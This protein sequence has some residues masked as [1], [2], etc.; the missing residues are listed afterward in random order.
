MSNLEFDLAEAFA[1]HTRKHCFVTGR[2]GTGKTTLLKRIAERSQ[3]NVVV[4]APTGVAAV[5][6][7]GATL[8]S[9]FGL[10]LTCFVPNDDSVDPR[11]ATN[12]R[13][14]L[15]EHLRLRKEKV[16]VLRELDLLIIDEVS[17][18]RCDMLDA[19]DLV[20]RR[21]RDERRPFGG[22]QVLLIGDVHQLP[23]VARDAEWSV[24][25]RYYG[26]PYFFDSLVW[27][28]LDAARIELQ[29]IYRQNDARF[30][31][32][33]ENI[34]NCK[35]DPADEQNL[36]ERY[37][38]QFK[39]AEAGHVL[40]TTHNRKADDVNAAELNALA[41]NAYSFTAQID[42]EFP[43]HLYPC[44]H[45]LRLKP[46]AQVM[47]IRNDSQEGRYY[48]GKLA[49]VKQIDGENV[50][51]TF[52]DSG[53]DYILRRE[54]WENIGYSVE[55]E[56]GKVVKEELGT[57]SQ[58]PLRL[59][60][61]ITIH[62]SQGLTFDKVTVDAARS[63]E[64]GQVYV[65]LSRCRTLE[66][67]VL[68]SRITADALRSNGRIGDFSAS[69]HHANELQELLGPEKAR[70]ANE[71]LMR[72]FTFGEW[73]EAMMEWQ[74]LIAAQKHL[75]QESAVALHARIAA[76]SS[77]IK[78]T[79][80]KFQQQLRRLIHVAERDTSDAVL[81]ER[82]AKAIEYFTA[83]I[84]TQLVPPLREHIAVLAYKQKL[85]R[86]VRHVQFIEERCWTKIE[87]LY[88]AQ[89]LDR[90]LYQ[91]EIAHRRNG[92]STPAGAAPRLKKEKGAT[93]RD[94]LDLYRQG[95]TIEQIAALR[96]L[97]IGT[98]KSHME[99]WIKSG[100]IDLAEIL[101]APLIDAVVAFIEENPSATL[102]QIR[103]AT[104]GA[105]D[106]SDIRLV[107]A[108]RDREEAE[109]GEGDALR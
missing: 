95:N 30:L 49:T 87:R 101:P 53:D 31:S 99:R 79:A 24:L 59:A 47:F 8:H 80:E 11:V 27:P 3:K 56:S 1:L 70:Y 44:E 54:V 55:R 102:T 67:I 4:V 93:Y 7:G 91:G 72:L 57:F 90:K 48:N 43:E 50:T 14:F 64:A 45:T 105:Y 46:G 15:S 85:K 73:S 82:C 23:P 88:A 92:S 98:I 63:F 96:G 52:R 89:F 104:G 34:R 6:A 94:T 83:Q 13:Q 62:K 51:V 66:G 69:H 108:H 37:D 74:E 17:M 19:V 25:Q 35:L 60:W 107:K 29:T 75:D 21:V 12:R 77:E 65:A 81:K 76:S 32:L 68:Q 40:L 2:A 39:S 41:G 84:A 18:V 10:P 36:S 58:Y 38:P 61:A 20:L 42:G 97:A 9:M 16:R 26:S 100:D 71:L 78:T 106:F 22:V 103:V 5:N 33:L 86:Y 109:V 28:Q